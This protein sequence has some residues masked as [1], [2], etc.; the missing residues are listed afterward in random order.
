MKTLSEFDATLKENW[1]IAALSKELGSKSPLRRRI[2]EKNYA[3]Y[4]DSEG[5][6]HALEDRCLHRGTQLSQGKCGPKGLS[7]PYHGWTYD[8]NGQVMDIPSEGPSTPELEKNIRSRG[9]RIS[10]P[11]LVEQEGV[12]WLWTGEQ[13][14]C[15]ATPTWKFPFAQDSNWTHYWMLTDFENEVDHLVQNFMDVPHTVFVHSKWFRDQAQMKVPYQLQVKNGRV[16]VTYLQPSDSIG[17]WMERLIN[18]QKAQMAHTDE[19]IFPNLTQVIYR[20]GD[21]GFAINSQC[22]PVNRFHSRVYTWIAYR[23]SRL[24]P[25]LKPLIHA[26]T[27]QV[28][29]QDVRI[30]R[31][32]GNNLKGLSANLEWKSTPADEIH[33]AI[34]KIRNLGRTDAPAAFQLEYERERAF[35]I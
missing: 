29:E 14:P 34:M 16:K 3:L 12:L 19:F 20:F 23:G 2:Y 21:C 5:V 22:T 25:L 10:A 27:R 7:C 13:V 31:N 1:Y 11:K 15:P 4:R 35:W 32:Q 17:R 30:M 24:A 26:Y 9:W 6:A 8:K 18:P 28:I 33:L